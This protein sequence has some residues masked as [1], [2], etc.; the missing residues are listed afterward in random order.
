MSYR[1]E[2]DVYGKT[3]VKSR[4]KAR[5]AVLYENT[6][7]GRDLLTGFTRAIAGKGPKIVRERPTSSPAPTS[8]PRSRS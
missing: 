7:L 2:G 1:G 4:P 5:I 8:R 6:E 3:I